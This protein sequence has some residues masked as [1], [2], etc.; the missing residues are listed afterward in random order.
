MAT[1]CGPMNNKTA[2]LN[3][4]IMWAT[5]LVLSSW[6]LVSGISGLFGIASTAATDALTA[7]VQSDEL[8]LPSSGDIQDLSESAPAVTAADVDRVTS[9]AA[10]AG[11]SFLVGALIALATALFGAVA[12]AKKPRSVIR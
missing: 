5:T 1:C 12:G 7:V 4:T 9:N 11:F 6:L 3:A 2:M 8:T 10:G